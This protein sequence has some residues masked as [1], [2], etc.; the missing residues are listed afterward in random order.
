MMVLTIIDCFYIFHFNDLLE[1]G[2]LKFGGY[3]NIY[4]GYES[5]I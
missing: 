5:I 3:E 4:Q 2:V 1:A